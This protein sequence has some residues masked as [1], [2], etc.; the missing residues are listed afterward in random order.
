MRY[1]HFFYKKLRFF[2]TESFLAV[3]YIESFHDNFLTEIMPGFNIQLKLRK[4]QF[5]LKIGHLDVIKLYLLKKLVTL[6]VFFFK[7]ESLIFYSKFFELKVGQC[8]SCDYQTNNNKI[9]RSI[10]RKPNNRERYCQ[11]FFLGITTRCF[12]FFLN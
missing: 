3:S 8:N 12:S 10:K 11:V 1:T 9:W 2:S 5:F 6:N 4:F 7:D